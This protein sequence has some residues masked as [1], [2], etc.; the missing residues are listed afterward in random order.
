MIKIDERSV[1]YKRRG[2]ISIDFFYENDKNVP[3]KFKK[4]DGQT[5]RTENNNNDKKK[6]KKK[7]EREPTVYKESD[8][9]AADVVCYKT[10]YAAFD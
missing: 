4:C 7:G 3:N 5:K 8:N 2:A 10:L 1:G 6:N 9:N